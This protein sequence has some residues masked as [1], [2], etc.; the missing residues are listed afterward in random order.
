MYISTEQILKTLNDQAERR[1][2]KKAKSKKQK[3]MTRESIMLM[4]KLRRW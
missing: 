2:M 4:R 1:F 3:Q